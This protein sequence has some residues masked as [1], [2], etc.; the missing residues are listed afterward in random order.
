[1]ADVAAHD[2]SVPAGD[3]DRDDVIG[4]LGDAF[5]DGSLGFEEFC[6]RHD[7][8]AC[9]R[10]RR[11]LYALV[12]DLG[13]TPTSRSELVVTAD[14]ARQRRSG[15][16]VVP[17]RL[18]V[19][20]AVHDVLLDFTRANCAHRMV[21]VQ[22]RPGLGRV[23]VIVPRGWAVRA[24]QVRSDWGSVRCNVPVDPVG[25]LPVIVMAG[26][27]GVGRVVIRRPRFSLP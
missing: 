17:E 25:E 4:V 16:W 19:T 18:L 2:P 8:A 23:R 24:D 27:V 20:A 13:Q 1:M 3:S 26:Q 15:Q 14:Q 11:E 6:H 9:A 10:T 5:A 22:I 7:R 21:L 12:G